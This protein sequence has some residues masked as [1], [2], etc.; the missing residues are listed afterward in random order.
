MMI[1]TKLFQQPFCVKLQPSAEDYLE[2]SRILAAAI[3]NP[4]FRK[5]LLANPMATL[6]KGYQGE[7]FNLSDDGWAGLLSLTVGSL[8]ELASALAPVFARQQ[9]EHSTF[10]IA[11]YPQA[12]GI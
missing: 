10:H 5:S 2:Y 1:N 9:P 7:A 11:E 12:G 3:V 8:P 6:R 4:H